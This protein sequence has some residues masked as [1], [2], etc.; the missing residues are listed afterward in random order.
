M[1]AGGPLSTL[2]SLVYS[3]NGSA[4]KGGEDGPCEFTVK[5]NS[6]STTSHVPMPRSKLA[7]RERIEKKKKKKEKITTKGKKCIFAS[8]NFLPLCNT[9]TYPRNPRS[10]GLNCVAISSQSLGNLGGGKTKLPM[11]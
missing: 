7:I 10:E 1:R 3:G 8:V 5:E 2:P 11:I 6:S 9:Q 4:W